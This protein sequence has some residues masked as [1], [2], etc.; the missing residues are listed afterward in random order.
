MKQDFQE[1]DAIR[2]FLGTLSE[3]GQLAFEEKFFTDPDFSEWLDEVE[4]DLIDDYLRGEL[5][6]TERMKFEENYLVTVQ[7]DARLKASRTLWEN[8]R[9][10]PEAAD[11]RLGESAFWE[12]F[13]AFFTVSQLSYAVPVILL[14]A[15]LGGIVFFMNRP[16]NEI[17]EKGNTNINS[18][19]NPAPFPTLKPESILP[20]PTLPPTQS[21]DP[22]KT[23]VPIVR[24][25]PP[26]SEKETPNPIEVPQPFIATIT[27]FPSLRGDGDARK[28]ILKK[29]TKSLY[30]RLDRDIKGDFENYRADLS[31][32]GGN[33]ISS[34]KLSGKKALGMTVSTKTLQN[35][36]YKITLK[37]ETSGGEFRSLS[38]YNFAIDKK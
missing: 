1:Q 3:A 20:T 9:S 7:R 26:P 10:A 13:K 11:A 12:S 17:A 23:E 30:L 4:T 15:L 25:T 16:S 28:I 33:L 38:F 19:L 36:S 27:L 34:Q 31:S 2:Y 35:G 32:A 21:I 5:S 22:Q 37:G 24:P 8:E 6:A 14:L 18:P 29:E